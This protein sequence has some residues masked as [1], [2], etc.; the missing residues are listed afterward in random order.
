VK[1]KVAAEAFPFEF[2][3]VTARAKKHGG[4]FELSMM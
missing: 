4:G 1:T 3:I 2:V